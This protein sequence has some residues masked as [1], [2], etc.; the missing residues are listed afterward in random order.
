MKGELP[1]SQLP[2]PSGISLRVLTRP[3]A[4][5]SRSPFPEARPRQEAPPHGPRG[6]PPD[7]LPGG[8]RLPYPSRPL[9]AGGQGRGAAAGREAQGGT[10]GPLPPAQE[11][12]VRGDL[13]RNPGS[14]SQVSSSQPS[15]LFLPTTK[16]LCVCVCVEGSVPAACPPISAYLVSDSFFGFSG[17]LLC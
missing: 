2:L 3:P 16:K 8:G 1:L 5:A 13:H 4:C 17:E 7:G 10:E 12:Q 15:S 9:P 14:L 11:R 6:G